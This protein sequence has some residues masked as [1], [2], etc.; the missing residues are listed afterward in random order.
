MP[1]LRILIICAVLIGIVLA[2]YYH[3]S[4]PSV[5]F[6]EE[7]I[8]IHVRPDYIEV[9]GRYVYVNPNPFPVIQAMFYPLPV[10]MQHPAPDGIT[11]INAGTGEKI[12][13]HHYFGDHRFTLFFMPHET[14]SVTVR[15]RQK[16]F[17]NRATYILLTTGLWK[18]PLDYAEYMV[19]AEGVR[20]TQSNYPLAK[21][22]NNALGFTKREFMPHEDWLIAWQKI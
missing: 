16:S 1:K 18:H 3:S 6:P 11:V 21:M 12:R 9:E 5:R 4:Y 2:A 14:K 15:Y 19:M 20:I 10:D 13:S 17:D 8:Y 7:Y 22:Q